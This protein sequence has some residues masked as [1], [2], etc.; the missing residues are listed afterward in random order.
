MR[1]RDMHTKKVFSSTY[2]WTTS[3]SYLVTGCTAVSA[4]TKFILD[5]CAFLGLIVNVPKSSL[6]PYQ[7]FVFSG[8]YFQ[9]VSFISPLLTDRWK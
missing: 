9:M 6:I 5:I 3:Y 8:I 2:I 4:G 1:Q 7:G